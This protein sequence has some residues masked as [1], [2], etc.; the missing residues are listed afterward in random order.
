MDLHAA[1]EA[2]EILR[3]AI[4]AG[5]EPRA[6]LAFTL[7]DLHRRAGRTAS[8]RESFDKALAADPGHFQTLIA[9]GRLDLEDGQI[10]RA[11]EFFRRA[12]ELHPDDWRP[13]YWLAKVAAAG[14]DPTQIGRLLARAQQL[15]GVVNTELL[16]LAGDRALAAGDAQQA[17]KLF[18]EGLKRDP[19]SLEC[20][21]GMEA[22]LLAIGDQNRA[23]TAR[24]RVVATAAL[25][26]ALR[27][28]AGSAGK[29]ADL[30]PA[31]EAAAAACEKLKLSA[32]RQ[33]FLTLAHA[34]DPTDTAVLRALAEGHRADEDL[35][36]RAHY[37]A[38]LL[39]LQPEDADAKRELS[40]IRA[41]LSTAKN[42]TTG[43]AENPNSTHFK[44]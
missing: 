3:G 21:E 11:V 17:G 10:D 9:C 29:F 15:A 20:A 1:E 4:A 40:A 42:R 30:G 31:L 23:A 28:L 22:V 7:G 39:K 38:E 12:S 41:R 13:A 43:E 16:G 25:H 18:L 32:R 34:A 19:E 33:Y 6:D 37:L 8:A 14:G 36:F 27:E 2:R 24:T 5:H 26:E 35:L 44:L